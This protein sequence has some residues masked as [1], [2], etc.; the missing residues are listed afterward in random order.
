M[1]LTPR[2]WP[3]QAWSSPAMTGARL[4]R[5]YLQNKVVHRLSSSHLLRV[6]HACS[7]SARLKQAD[8]QWNVVSSQSLVP[9][10]AGLRA[11]WCVADAS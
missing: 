4:A 8:K 5:T 9:L 6:G 2:G 1:A 7:C 11:F 10:I 3:G